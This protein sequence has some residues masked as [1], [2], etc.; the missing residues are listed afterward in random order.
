MQSISTENSVNM[1]PPPRLKNNI[2]SGIFYFREG[3]HLIWQAEL[4]RYLIVPLLVNCILFFVLTSAFI[5]YFGGIVD[6]SMGYL[7]AFLAPLEWIVWSVI[8]ILMLIVYAYSFNMITNIIA[9]PFYG[10]LA[11]KVEKILT[12]VAPPEESISTMITRTLLRECEK[13]WYFLKRGVVVILIMILVGTLTGWIPVLN[14]LAPLIGLA[15][16]AWTM[17]IQYSD[18]SADN[19]QLAFKP[20]RQCLWEKKYSSL[21]F[22]GLI[23]L[24]S[25][26]PV[27]NIIAMPVAVVGGNLFWLRELKHCPEGECPR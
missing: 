25:I 24:C 26:I 8:G 17:A 4:R 19:H 11:A 12:G 27:I 1:L 23:M 18:Y 16:G 13:L 3:L 15:W 14:L 21:G 9:A 10:L 5:H 2:A 6:S 7:P 20:L 22:G